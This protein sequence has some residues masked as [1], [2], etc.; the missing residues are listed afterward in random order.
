MTIEPTSGT[1]AAGPSATS[2]SPLVSCPSCGSGLVHPEAWN[3][4]PGGRI[5]LRIRCGEC[6]V[7]T[8]GEYE[9]A[10]VAAYDRALIEGRLELAALY[11]AVVRSNMRDEEERL[12]AAFTLDL[13][14]ADDFAGYNRRALRRRRAR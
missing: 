5:R 2:Q 1:P 8:A 10:E 14:S 3:V 9:A 7:E 12:H 13:I 6:R 11:E 4:R